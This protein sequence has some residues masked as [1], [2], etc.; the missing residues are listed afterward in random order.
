MKELVEEIEKNI[1][2]GEEGKCPICK[3]NNLEFEHPEMGDYCVYTVYQ[4]LD[5]GIS[6]TEIYSFKFEKVEADTDNGYITFLKQEE[7]E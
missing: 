4:C 1:L 2:R 5:C 7:V 6:S 3:S